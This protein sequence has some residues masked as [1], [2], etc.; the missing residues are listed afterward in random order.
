MKDDVEKAINLI[1][2]HAKQIL[3]AQ[4]HNDTGDLINKMRVNATEAAGEL[5][6]LHYGLAQETGIK[7]ENIPFGKGGGTS[8]YIDG[9]MAWIKRK[10]FESDIKKVR[11]MAFAIATSHKKHGMHTSGGKGNSHFDQS[12]QGFLTE[13]IKI[14]QKDVDLLISEGAKKQINLEVMK[15]WDEA[16]RNLGN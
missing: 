9:I 16:K 10:G 1:M 8:M 5:Y 12:K 13:A 2:F 15:M 4:G 11:G 6:G 14:T 7:K 3:A